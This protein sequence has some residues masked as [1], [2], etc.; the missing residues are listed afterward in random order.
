MWTH[1]EPPYST[2]HPDAFDSGLTYDEHAVIGA[3]AQAQAHD[4]LPCRECGSTA[5]PV[6]RKPERLSAD[7]WDDPSAYLGCADCGAYLEPLPV[8]LHYPAWFMGDRRA[9]FP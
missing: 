8:W 7:W 1:M 2:P 3:E 9:G 5:E 4:Q 6:T